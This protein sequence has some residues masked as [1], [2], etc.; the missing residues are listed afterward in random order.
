V[1]WKV[2]DAKLFEIAKKVK[3]ESWFEVGLK[4]D[5]TAI[6]LEQI[7][8]NN[9]N[10]S[11]VRKI[12][13]MLRLWRHKQEAIGKQELEVLCRSLSETDNTEALKLLE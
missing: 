3:C 4:L 11:V 1:E 12:F 2:K 6:E 13:N 8:E 5:L 10:Q 9:S 7:E